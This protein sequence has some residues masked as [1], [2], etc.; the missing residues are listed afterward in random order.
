MICCNKALI[1]LCGVNGK[2]GNLPLLF[3][4]F[5]DATFNNRMLKQLLWL[6]VLL[7]IRVLGINDYPNWFILTIRE[8]TFYFKEW[9]F[10]HWTHTEF[11]PLNAG[12][13]L[14]GKA[15]LTDLVGKYG[16]SGCR[17]SVWLSENCCCCLGRVQTAVV[18]KQ[19]QN[20][21]NICIILFYYLST[22]S[23]CIYC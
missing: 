13:G 16:E 3:F 20:S 17:S 14:L 4:S 9:H 1:Q 21:T 12:E 23:A 11:L 8:T 10:C 19:L 18:G 15:A 7:W 6:L 2:C 5:F 22:F